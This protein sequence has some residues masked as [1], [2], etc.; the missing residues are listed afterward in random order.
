MPVVLTL[1]EAEVGGSFDSMHLGSAWA[2]WG[3]LWLKNKQIK[4]QGGLNN[5]KS[6]IHIC[7][8]SAENGI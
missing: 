1:E 6:H 8:Y 4:N 7:R 2:P 5:R 3:S